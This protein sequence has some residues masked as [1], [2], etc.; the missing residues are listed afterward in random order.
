M[1]GNVAFVK[2]PETI[3]LADREALIPRLRVWKRKFPGVL[4]GETAERCLTVLTGKGCVL[5]L[6]HT[7]SPLS[8]HL[9]A[10]RAHDPLLGA[11]ADLCVLQRDGSHDAHGARRRA[12]GRPIMRRS[13]LQQRKQ[14]RRPAF[15]M[16]QVSLRVAAPPSAFR[17][18][19]LPHMRPVD[20]Y[21]TLLWIERSWDRC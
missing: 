9:D 8:A 14:R 18:I 5:C 1:K 4:A 13:R 20:F 11:H 15:A 16:R 19:S 17:C 7:Y 12:E 6:A 2:P 3:P 21:S 10:D